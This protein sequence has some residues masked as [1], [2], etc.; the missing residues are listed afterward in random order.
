QYAQRGFFTAGIL[1]RPIL[2]AFR[3]GSHT[4]SALERWRDGREH[5]H[6]VFFLQLRQ[7]QQCLIGVPRQPKDDR[8]GWFRFQALAF[9]LP[10]VP[11][12]LC[13]PI[14]QETLF[15]D[16][17]SHRMLLPH[18]AGLPKDLDGEALI[19]ELSDDGRQPVND[20]VLQHEGAAMAKGG[21][22]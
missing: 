16:H 22:Q 19:D 3:S 6:E 18:R 5:Y 13:T 1:K 15:H 7:L 12:D 10:N 17:M 8:K 9:E 4:R 21:V 14:P 2:S 11:A 20:S